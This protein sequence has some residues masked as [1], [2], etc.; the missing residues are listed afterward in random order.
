LGVECCANVKKGKVVVVMVAK[1]PNES[2]R[3]FW[4]LIR[5]VCAVLDF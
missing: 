3:Y 5:G 4:H 2:V 1:N